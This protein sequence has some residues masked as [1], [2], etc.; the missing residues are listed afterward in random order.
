MAVRDWFKDKLWGGGDDK[1]KGSPGNI[2]NISRTIQEVGKAV[3]EGFRGMATDKA[4]GGNF[5]G[6]EV[7]FGIKV[8]AQGNVYV[9][10]ASMEA[11]LK[12]KFTWDFA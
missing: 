3:T 4:A 5:A 2:E 7:E 10:K 11:N 9:T 1:D 12:V 8:S 6:A